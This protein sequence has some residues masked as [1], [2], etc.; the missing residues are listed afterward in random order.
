[1]R[2]VAMTAWCLSNGLRRRTQRRYA[3][4]CLERSEWL[5]FFGVRWRGLL[6]AAEA[7]ERWVC[8]GSLRFA[9]YGH[10]CFYQWFI[11]GFLDASIHCVWYSAAVKKAAL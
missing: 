1:M 9:P 6:T 11:C 5:V 8:L 2:C 10:H 3:S 4:S 7:G